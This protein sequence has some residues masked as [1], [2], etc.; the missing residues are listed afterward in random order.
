MKAAD[1]RKVFIELWREGKKKRMSFWAWFVWDWGWDF[2][3]FFFF[4]IYSVI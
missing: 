1:A 3:F 2:F 4:F